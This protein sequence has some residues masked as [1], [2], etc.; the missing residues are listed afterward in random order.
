MKG[1]TGCWDET[2][3]LLWDS[4][5][6]ESH[7]NQKY[8]LL[9]MNFTNLNC[10]LKLFFD[11]STVHNCTSLIMH[12]TLAMQFF[13]EANEKSCK[14]KSKVRLCKI[15]KKSKRT[16]IVV[17]IHAAFQPQHGRS[18]VMLIVEAL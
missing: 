3:I 10:K 8:A 12:L 11:S 17:E 2:K 5:I 16:T 4:N 6:H 9:T 1:A 7:K 13:V 18:Y 15:Y 14:C